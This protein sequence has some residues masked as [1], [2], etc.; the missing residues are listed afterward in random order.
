MGEVTEYAPG[1]PN[2]AELATPD[3][4]VS[5]AFYRELLGWRSFTIADDRL[6]DYDMWTLDEPGDPEVGWLKALADDSQR[7]SWTCYISVDDMEAALKR[8]TA[9]GGQV[10]TDPV[11]VGHLGRMALVG[12]PEGADLG[13][14]QAYTFQGAAVVGEP[15]AM[16]WAELACRDPGRAEE[17]YAR[18]F[19]WT[20]ARRDYYAA[21]YTN[22]RVGG[23]SM[24][25]ILAMDERWSPNYPAHWIPYFAV[26]DCD[27]YAAKAVELGATI[28]VPPTDI[29]PGRFTHLADPTGVRVALIKPAHWARPDL[30]ESARTGPLARFR[31]RRAGPGRDPR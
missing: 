29:P 31:S 14:W 13:L 22:W 7:P 4:R 10:L 28:R 3:I 5:R 24:G 26:T 2:L 15:G 16:C 25:G 27:A 20:F 8:V 23:R 12:D 30:G 11:D 21:S 18:V 17:F 19:G 9:A 1:M 6:G